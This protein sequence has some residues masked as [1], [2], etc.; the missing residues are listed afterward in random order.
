MGLCA[1]LNHD[2]ICISLFKGNR[3]DVSFL[4]IWWTGAKISPNT[5]VPF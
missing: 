1:G 4:I 2:L 5:I 3:H